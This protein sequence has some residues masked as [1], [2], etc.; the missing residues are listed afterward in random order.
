MLKELSLVRLF[1]HSILLIQSFDS[2]FVGGSERQ[3][4]NLPQVSGSW[5]FQCLSSN[6]ES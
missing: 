6:V 1:F 4:R 5:P 3:T 2:K